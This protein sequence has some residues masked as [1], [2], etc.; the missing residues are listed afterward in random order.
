MKWPDKNRAWTCSVPGC[1]FEHPDSDV[2]EDHLGERHPAL[3]LVSDF[4]WLNTKRD[5]IPCPS[6]SNTSVIR[7]IDADGITEAY[8]RVST[9][10]SLQLRGFLQNSCQSVAN[11]SMQV[12]DC[13]VEHLVAAAGEDVAFSGVEQQLQDVDEFHQPTDAKDFAFCVACGVSLCKAC[14]GE[15]YFP[16]TVDVRSSAGDSKET[17]F[18]VKGTPQCGCFVCH[19]CFED[20]ER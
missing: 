10:V 3:C 1:D 7:L 19:D 5:D 12:T 13:C 6:S 2:I 16:K 15:K 4:M 14:M 8:K 20:K 18:E 17:G 11:V 9:V